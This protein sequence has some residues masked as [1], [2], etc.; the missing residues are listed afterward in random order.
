MKALFSSSSFMVKYC[1]TIL[2]LFGMVPIANAQTTPPKTTPLPTREISGVIKDAKGN[3]I[4]GA[5]IRLTSPTDTAVTTSNADGIFVFKNIKSASYTLEVKSLAYKV[6]VGKFLQNDAIPRIIMDPIILG[7]SS[8]SIDE[9]V[10]EGGSS[11]TYKVDTVEYR[12]SDYVVRE[13]ATVDELLKKM[14]DM[15]VGTDGSVS[16]QGKELTKAKING[17]TYLGGKVNEAVQN[18]PANI[19]DK[20]QVV[21]DYGDEA[22]RTGIKDGDP[23]KILNIVTKT[24]KSV[25]NTLNLAGGAGNNDRYESSLF[26]TRL[27][28]NQT[29]GLNARLNNTVTGVAG[30]GGGNMGGG[31]GGGVPIMIGGGGGI[32]IGGGGVPTFGGSNSGGASGGVST[33]GNTSFSIRDRVSKVLEYNANYSFSAGR[34]NSL[35]SSES[36]NF[37]SLGTTFATNDQNSLNKNENH[38]FNAELEFNF[39]KKNFLRIQPNLTVTN[40]NGTSLSSVFQTG[41]IHQDQV[42]SNR[43]L[44]KSPSFGLSAFYQ[45]QFDK[46]RRNI[47]TSINFN[48]ADRSTEQQN[49]ANIIYYQDDS[50]VVLKDSLVNRLVERS[51]KSQS[52]RANVS[53]VEPLSGNT[54]LEFSGQFNRNSYDNK[55]ITSNILNDERRISIDS[56]SNIF[57]YSFNQSRISLNYRYGLSNTSRVKF[58]VGLAGLPS[59][60]IGSKASLGT[61][62]RRSSFN[63][64]PVARFQYSWSMQHSIQVNYNGNASE[65]SFDQI[66]PVRDVSNVQN[67][68]VGN[69]NLKVAFR[70]AVNLN[71]N[72]YIPRSKLNYSVGLNSSMTE[73]SISRNVVQISDEYNSLKNETRYVNLQGVYS[74]GGNYSI[75]KQLKDRK[76]SLAY[77]GNFSFNHGVS[78][79]NDLINYTDRWS[80]SQRFGPRINP[81]KWLEVN[82]SVSYRFLSS[83]NSL[84]SSIDSKTKTIAL[85]IDGRFNFSNN[86]AMGYNASKNFVSGINAN[87]TNNP[88]VINAFIQKDVWNRRGAITVQ[89]FD[90]LNQNNFINRDVTDQSIVDT[91]TNALSRYFMVK[92]SMRLQKWSGARA[93]NGGN[94]IRMGDGSFVM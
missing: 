17:K 29:L 47:S 38:N 76:Y 21:D 78:M 18:L 2:V 45:H 74:V 86:F 52:I 72:N 91:K 31:G 39:N 48:N 70:H 54:Q 37:S 82:P 44:N 8:T 84:P 51:N 77:S 19:V 20:I 85:N 62:I 53:F 15:E 79:S 26:A 34:V 12:A 92:L 87:V 3:E 40:S 73:N 1:L 36:Q 59:L 88:F 4:P 81:N 55:A 46:R 68:V 41:L 56:L 22:A 49:N 32:S 14:E 58:S 25:G 16:H 23:E 64:I 33:T 13:N 69:P 57:D 83:N 9:V 11:I 10:I 42:N 60:M 35:N 24:D 90:L 27:N 65:P 61:N 43:N 89:A 71:Y 6:M 63:L 50:D 66:Q 94:I 93:R 67:P 5:N 28:G 80:F 75:S 7:E 30:G